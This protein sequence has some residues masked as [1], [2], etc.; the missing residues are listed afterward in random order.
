MIKVINLK[1]KGKEFWREVLTKSKYV[2]IGRRV[3]FTPFKKSK[4]F[5]PFSIK[6]YGRKKSIKMYKDYILKSDLL[7]QLPELKDKILCCWCKPKACHGD[8][9]IQLNN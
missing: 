9:L 2:Y 3:A 7:N 1:E 5:N 4:W 6:Q 8:I